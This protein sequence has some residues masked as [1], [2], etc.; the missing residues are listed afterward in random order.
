[1]AEKYQSPAAQKRAEQR[2]RK[3]ENLAQSREAAKARAGRAAPIQQ[4]VTE[5][6][7][8]ATAQASAR[9]GAKKPRVMGPLEA[10]AAARSRA[11]FGTVYTKPVSRGTATFDKKTG[12]RVVLKPE[13]MHKAGM[14]APKISGDMA[15]AIDINTATDEM[16]ASMMQRRLEGPTSMRLSEPGP[17]DEKSERHRVLANLRSQPIKQ[18]DRGKGPTKF[19]KVQTRTVPPESM[20]DP[21]KEPTRPDILREQYSRGPREGMGITNQAWQGMLATR[22]KGQAKKDKTAAQKQTAQISTMRSER[23]TMLS[24]AHVHPMEKLKMDRAA[25]QAAV[26]RGENVPGY[27]ASQVGPLIVGGMRYKTAQDLKGVDI[28]PTSWQSPT[29]SQMPAPSVQES[30]DAFLTRFSNIKQQ[31]MRLNMKDVSRHESIMNRRAAD[32][33]R[34]AAGFQTAANPR[35]LMK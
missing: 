19:S 32:E 3:K 12:K 7:E 23:D 29:S 11:L 2:A 20:V 22:S 28:S 26:D 1:M 27:S 16:V 13:E 9:T 33:K 25:L 24:A 17:D 30:D 21:V 5:A 4:V 15:A 6:A 10:A 34:K 14:Q 8:S 18:E 35:D 31:G